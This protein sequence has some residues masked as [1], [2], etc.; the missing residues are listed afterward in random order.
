MSGERIEAFEVGGVERFA[1]NIKTWAT[2]S[3]ADKDEAT[4]LEAGLMSAEDKAAFDALMSNGYETL[5]NK[6][7]I[8]SVTLSGNKLFPDLGVFKTDDQGYSVVDEY[9]LT[10]MDI[11]ALWANSHPIG[12]G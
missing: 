5:A 1:S 3:F 7:Q 11:N 9:T 12:Q 8:E 2:A 4:Q 10:T 6:P